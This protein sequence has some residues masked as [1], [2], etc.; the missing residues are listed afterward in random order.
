M[1]FLVP[2]SPGDSHTGDRVGVRS[3]CLCLPG[4]SFRPKGG[5]SPSVPGAPVGSHG[6]WKTQ[7]LHPCAGLH[8]VPWSLRELPDVTMQGPSH[9]LRFLVK[10]PI[11]LLTKCANEGAHLQCVL[12]GR[13]VCLPGRRP[14]RRGVGCAVSALHPFGPS[15]GLRGVLSLRTCG[16]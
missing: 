11:V 1:P 16:D 14:C 9:R 5:H 2:L 8:C 15:V 13:G 4:S 7:R 10:R 3:S 12:V 6:L